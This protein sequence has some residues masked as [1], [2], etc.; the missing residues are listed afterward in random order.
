M[1]PVVFILL[2]HFIMFP[3]HIKVSGPRVKTL[4]RSIEKDSHM[5][6]I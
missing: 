3:T 4:Y 6:A 2:I 1:I 5:D